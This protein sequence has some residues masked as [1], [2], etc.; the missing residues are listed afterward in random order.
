MFLTIGYSASALN[1]NNHPPSPGSIQ[2]RYIFMQWCAQGWLT[3]SWRMAL[4]PKTLKMIFYTYFS[5]LLLTRKYINHDMY[6][7][8]PFQNI[9]ILRLFMIIKQ[10]KILSTLNF[11]HRSYLNSNYFCSA[12]IVNL[13][14]WILWSEWYYVHDHNNIGYRVN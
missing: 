8:Q 13:S 1:R 5:V 2:K 3:E 11:Y 6:K 12:C 10:V 9:K 4:T 14:Y 7:S